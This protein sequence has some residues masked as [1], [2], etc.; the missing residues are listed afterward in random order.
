MSNLDYVQITSGKKIAYKF[1]NENYID[2][3]LLLFL[4]EGLGSIEAWKSFPQELSETLCLPALL[5]DRPGYGNSDNVEKFHYDYLENEAFHILPEFLDALNINKKLILFGHSDGGTIALLYAARHPGNVLCT[6]SEAGHIF[7]EDF[8]LKGL[9]EL[10]EK[11]ETT[12]MMSKLKKYHKEK[13]EK[14]F[15]NWL[16][17]WQSE[18]MKSWN[19]TGIIEQIKTPV[20]VLQGDD[21]EFGTNKQVY[22]IIDNIKSRYKKFKILEDCGH[23]PHITAKDEVLKISSKFIKKFI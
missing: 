23:A 22:Q 16:G 21:D 15:Y 19:I 13:T 5:Y 9:N 7:F 17:I 2:A 3:P 20:L 4:H 8:C 10:T 18:K 12:D 1:I 14:L 11:Y 6:I